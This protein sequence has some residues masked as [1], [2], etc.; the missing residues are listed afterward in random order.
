MMI[1]IRQ[2]IIYEFNDELD[3]MFSHVDLRQPRVILQYPD[4]EYPDL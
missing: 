4:I 2:K 1:E 3:E